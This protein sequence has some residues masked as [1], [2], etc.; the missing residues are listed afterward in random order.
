MRRQL[1]T[2]AMEVE[3][4]MQVGQDGPFGFNAIYPGQG[5]LHVE[6]AG[7][8]PIAQSIHH[9]DIDSRQSRNAGRWQVAQ[10]AGIGKAVKSKPEG[11]DI[12]VLLQ[13]RQSSDRTPCP[14]M[15]S[16]RPA[17]S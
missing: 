9:P 2:E 10:I 5:I 12:A 17:S 11:L 15:F 3:I 13:N 8:R 16:A 7:M 14:V 4:G 1:R 6:M